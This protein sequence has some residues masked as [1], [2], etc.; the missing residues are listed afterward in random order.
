MSAFRRNGKWVAKF[1]LDGTQHWVPGGPWERKSHA[2]EAER[3]H[4]SVDAARR[5]L[6]AAFEIPEHPT[7]SNIGSRGVA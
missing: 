6:L 4:R 2:V 7:G 3:R 5:R 1:T